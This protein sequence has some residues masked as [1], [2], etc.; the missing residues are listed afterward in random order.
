ML[1]FGRF[2]KFL[3][4]SFL[5]HS[6]LFLLNSTNRF[7]FNS[8]EYWCYVC[9]ALVFTDRLIVYRIL[10]LLDEHLYIS[11]ILF[12]NSSPFMS[13]TWVIPIRKSRFD[14]YS[15]IKFHHFL[16]LK[17]TKTK[18]IIHLHSLHSFFDSISLLSLSL[19]RMMMIICTNQKNVKNYQNII[20]I[21]NNNITTIIIELIFEQQSINN[22]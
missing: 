15:I 19:D 1:D 22:N 4:F 17:F 10:P 16:F 3:F 13:N 20:I 12:S 2:W 14:I 7:D 6:N 5:V 18:S 11:L 8:F 9:F 21:I